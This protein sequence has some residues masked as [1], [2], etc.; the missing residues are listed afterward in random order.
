MVG[1]DDHRHVRHRRAGRAHQSPDQRIGHLDRRL[2]RRRIRPVVMLGVVDTGEVHRH[3]LRLVGQQRLSKGHAL[4]IA[5]HR[6]VDP[7][8][9]AG[10]DAAFQPRDEA[11]R[12]QRGQQLAIVL[13][14]GTPDLRQIFI[15]PRRADGHRPVDVGGRQARGMRCLPQGRHL[16]VRR[17]P[18]PAALVLLFGIE[19]QVVHHAMPAGRHARHQRGVA[20]VGERRQHAHHPLCARALRPQ[21][22]EHGE[23]HA[24]CLRIADIAGAQAV[25]R[26]HQHRRCR[27]R[28]RQQQRDEGREPP[29][30]K[31]RRSVTKNWRGAPA[32]SV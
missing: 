7:L 22:A 6:L 5:L 25:E 28:A 11:G 29:H 10:A 14:A 4:R 30:Q 9:I 20:G 8:R 27:C 18:I 24:P 3:E 17:I 16:H 19:R 1:H 23:V 2:R 26:D 32:S 13:G 21:A 12:R 31:P 15:D